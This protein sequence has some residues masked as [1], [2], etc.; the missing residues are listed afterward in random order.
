MQALLVLRLFY[1]CLSRISSL[2]LYIEGA[3]AVKRYLI[4]SFSLP[5]SYDVDQ[6]R[7]CRMLLAS[8]KLLRT[9]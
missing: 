7:F 1:R 5:D 6:V 3:A 9:F 4:F 8:I 2:N